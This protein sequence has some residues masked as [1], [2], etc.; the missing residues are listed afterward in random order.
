MNTTYI[1]QDDSDA[2]RIS[3]KGLLLWNEMNS[4]MFP[5]LS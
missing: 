3:L 4:S 1:T 5:P 2:D